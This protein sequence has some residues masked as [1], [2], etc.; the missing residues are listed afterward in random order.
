MELHQT[1]PERLEVAAN[2]EAMRNAVANGAADLHLFPELSLTGYDLGARAREVAQGEG[3]PPADFGTDSCVIYGFPEAAHDGRLFN[4]AGAARGDAWLGVH[5]KVH[6]PTYG[7]FQEGDL[8]RAWQ[9]LRKA[10]RP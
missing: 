4:V 9:H 3:D 5:R 8:L 7:A 1:A 6:L 2:L 10:K